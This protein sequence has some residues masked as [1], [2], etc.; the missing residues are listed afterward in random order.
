MSSALWSFEVDHTAP[1][2]YLADEVL[3]RETVKGGLSP[4]TVRSALK[5]HLG[6]RPVTLDLITPDGK[7]VY[8]RAVYVG[9]ILLFNWLPIFSAR[10][11]ELLLTEGC[12]A[13]EFLDCRLRVLGQASFQIHVPLQSYDVIDLA[14]SVA[15]HTVPHDPPIPVH[16]VSAHLKSSIPA[17]PPC[18]RVPAPGHPQV[19]A[20]LFAQ[21]SLHT[22][23]SVAGFTGAKFRRLSHG[24]A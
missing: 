16:F 23:W 24:A 3:L 19:L 13:E 4:G 7:G 21:D 12:K 14:R 10:A 2:T 20:E 15:M 5:A 6:E 17:L 8:E 1:E 22:A 9:D 18:F 11:H